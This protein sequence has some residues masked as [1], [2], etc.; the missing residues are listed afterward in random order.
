MTRGPLTPARSLLALALTTAVFLAGSGAAFASDGDHPPRW[1]F[2]AN[3][4]GDLPTCNW[5]GTSWHR[6]FDSASGGS[7]GGGTIAGLFV[8]A[9][10]ASVGFTVWKV[11]TARRMARDA[12]MS[13]GDATTM[14]LLTDDGFE[15][16]YLASNLRGHPAPSEPTRTASAGERLRQLTQLRDQGLITAEEHDAR[17]AAILDSL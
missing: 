15:A 13:T 11:T 7:G 3:S 9:L 14:T 17:R 2:R 4:N 5:D 6:S 16:T 8:L 10:V 12:G 1:C